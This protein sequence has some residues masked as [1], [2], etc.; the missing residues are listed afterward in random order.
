MQ[1]IQTT[2][3]ATPNW[4]AYFG[5]TVATAFLAGAMLFAIA[6]PSLPWRIDLILCGALTLA[7]G[8]IAF[9]EVRDIPRYLTIDQTTKCVTITYLARRIQAFRPDKACRIRAWDSAGGWLIE[10]R[11]P[12]FWMIFRPRDWPRDIA[13]KLMTQM[14]EAEV[15]SARQ[16]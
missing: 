14:R 8:G 2:I 15:E 5:V 16:A 4:R 6:L 13:D 10:F 1:S 12:S 3:R 11:D 7:F 9:H